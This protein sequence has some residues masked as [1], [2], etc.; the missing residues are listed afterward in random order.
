MKIFDLLQTKNT[1]EQEQ[2]VEQLIVRTQNPVI[3]LAVSHDPLSGES[4][5]QVIG[6]GQVPAE[7]VINVLAA[8]RDNLVRQVA[9]ARAKQ[10]DSGED[11]V[12]V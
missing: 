2:R 11:K 7:V 8:V 10:A 1:K 6:G 3:H 9:E 4:A 5:L 12:E